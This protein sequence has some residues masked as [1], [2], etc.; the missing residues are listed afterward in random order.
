MGW[1]V[2]GRHQGV[3]TPVPPG[4]HLHLPQRAESTKTTPQESHKEPHCGWGHRGTE[5]GNGLL[6]DSVIAISWDAGPGFREDG[7]HWLELSQA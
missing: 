4:C 7:G 6:L 1:P 2:L 5:L 3:L